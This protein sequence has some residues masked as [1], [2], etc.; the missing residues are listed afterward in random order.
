M[1]AGIMPSDTAP[2][3]ILV[4]DLVVA[5]SIGAYAHEHHARQRVRVNVT[6]DATVDPAQPEDSLRRVISYGDIVEG[7]RALA[8]GRHFNLA[9]T[10]AE[11]I[12]ALS[13]AD[14]RAIRVTV[15][16]EKL[17]VFPE[18][19]VGVEIERRRVPA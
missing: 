10:L 2:Y 19:V 17:D 16:V 9:E 8:A 15:R 1:F 12:A 4:R 18:A 3:R 11:H 7:T 6:L 5:A 13:L 14:P